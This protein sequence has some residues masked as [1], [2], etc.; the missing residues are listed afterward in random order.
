MEQQHKRQLGQH[1]LVEQLEQLMIFWGWFVSLGLW[2]LGLRRFVESQLEQR[3]LV[4]RLGQQ[5]QQLG[6]RRLV[7]SSTF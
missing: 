4:G 1:T 6:Q 5:R 2:S 7:L 3:Q